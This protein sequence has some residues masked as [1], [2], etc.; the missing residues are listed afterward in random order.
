[1]CV[2]ERECVKNLFLIRKPPLFKI[3]YIFKLIHLKYK[4]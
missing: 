1:M 3:N 4:L 2:Y